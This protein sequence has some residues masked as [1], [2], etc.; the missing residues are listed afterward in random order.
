MY[1]V[2]LRGGIV[3]TGAMEGLAD[4]GIEDG[5][6][7]QLGGSMEGRREIDATGLHVL[8]GGIDVHVHLS[9]PH[10]QRP[11]EEVWV[12]DFRSGSQAAVAGGVTTIGNMTFQRAGESLHAALE[13]DHEL[14]R[15]QA[16]ID[17]VLHPV[18][19]DPRPEVVA[20]I[21]QLAAEGHTSIK[22]FMVFPEFDSRIAEYTRAIAA[23]G[24]AGSLTMI[25]CED[26][27]AIHC[28]CEAL[29][30]AGRGQ[31]SN[32]PASRPVFAEQVAAQ[33]A[34]GI[35]RSTGAPMYVVHLSSQAAL[36]VCRDARAD[37]VPLL[38]ETRPIYLH[39]T[40]ERFAEPDA[41]KYVGAPA[42]RS[43]SDRSR[44][45]NGLRAADIQTC[46][47]DHAPWNLRQKLD[48]SLNVATA[49][50][51]V[52]DL[53][54]MLPMLLSEGVGPGQL[55]PSRFVE[56]TSTNAAKLFGL[57]PGKGTIAVGSD[58]DL[59]V[60]DLSDRRTVDGARMRSRAGYS[61]Y[62]GWEVTGWPAMT[63][64]RGEVIF[65]QGVISGRPGRGR[66]LRRGPTQPL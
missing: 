54:T 59:V 19:T 66:W 62:D 5:V 63:L 22:V 38:V 14:A 51:G 18:V 47:T 40:E 35:C 27:N 13:R 3:V 33:R 60:W 6:V 53:E 12:D 39:L 56:V 41:G 36:D 25:H 17:Y 21:P 2:V 31:L 32:F 48:P 52:A 37:G 58:A 46:C 50:Q 20:E 45:W 64:S 57:Y 1:E 28:A 43:G 24:R 7:A 30:A 10:E 55:T 26:S 42:L 65:E 23:A 8:P 34:V 15:E 44:L 16:L 61:V 49:R 9:T 11:G 4:I 29:L